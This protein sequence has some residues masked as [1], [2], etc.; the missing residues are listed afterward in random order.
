MKRRIFS[1]IILVAALALLTGAVPA[2]AVESQQGTATTATFLATMD[3]HASAW[4]PDASFGD[5]EVLILRQPDVTRAFAGFDLSAIPLYATV[6][7]AQLK[8][9]STYRTN[10]NAL[11][12]Y[13]YAALEPWDEGVTWTS[14]PA[15][16]DTPVAMMTLDQVDMQV[17]LDVTDL[18]QSWVDDPASNFGLGLLADDT[19]HVAYTFIASEMSTDEQG[20]PFPVLE[21]TYGP[22]A[23]VEILVEGAAIQGANGSTIGPDGNLYVASILGG[24][25]VVV[26]PES[27]EILDRIGSE[28]S[29]LG[30]DD[31]IFGPDGSLYWTDLFV[32]EVGRMAPDGQVTRQSVAVGVNPITFSDDGRLFVSLCV[33]GDGLYELDPDLVD[34]P[35]LIAEN[36]G[37]GACALNGMD[38]GPDGYLYGPRS[39][40]PGI[41]RVD[42]DTDELTLVAEQIM[43]GALKFDSQG[44][45]YL[46]SGSDIFHVD[47]ETWEA[48]LFATVPFA[49]DNLCFDSEDRMFVSSNA[50]G[51]LAEVLADGT[52]RLLLEGGM[53]APMGLAA[54]ERAGGE[55]SVYVADVWLVREFDGLSGE[56]LMQGASPALGVATVWPDGE[57]VLLTSWFANVVA[58]WDPVTQATLEY[59][60]DFAVPLNAIR[61]QEDLA[62]AELLTGSVV[63]A[64]AADPTQRETLASGLFVPAGLTATEDDLW[65][66]D[67]A[68]GIVWQIVADGTVLS[69]PVPVAMNLAN[70]EGLA[71]GP[72]GDLLVVESGAQRLSSIDLATGRV[73]TVAGGLA[74]GVPALPGYPP[75]W[76]FN[77]VAVGPSGA[78]YVSGD[79]GNVIYRIETGG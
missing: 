2:V 78:I 5:A 26:D 65:A 19:R 48:E 18:V 69:P 14:Q 58:V 37:G 53:I 35:R 57:N 21:V 38:F 76:W 11:H 51:T 16:A 79:V 28:R 23:S 73:K 36:L 71:V 10:V 22:P 12:L 7:E 55:E 59:H 52:L 74:L 70:P 46:A 9:Y 33:A 24:E 64:D 50:S 61:F 34:P 39:F 44:Q 40:F 32:G 31:V 77:G 8:L 56:E 60:G 68:S 6:H 62:V 1:I 75:T 45:M 72:Q 43:G 47:T 54:R 67:W 27:G 13:A 3:A 41:W 49:L 63:R 4:E 29:V 42:V 66:G 25:L 20:V 30:P 17:S 15:V